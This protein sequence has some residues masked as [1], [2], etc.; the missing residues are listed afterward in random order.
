MKMN[1]SKITTIFKGEFVMVDMVDETIELTVEN[2]VYSHSESIGL[3]AELQNACAV[4]RKANSMSGT[5]YIP[6]KKEW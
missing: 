1:E 6:P 2:N 3:L 5:N 4:A